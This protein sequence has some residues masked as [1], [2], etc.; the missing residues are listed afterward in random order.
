[1]MLRN[2]SRAAVGSSLRMI[3][4]PID[5][6]LAV[7][8]GDRA[9]VT[10]MKLTLDRADART[11]ELA[12]L[13]LGDPGLREDAELRRKAADKRERA[14]NLRAEAEL[15][16]ERADQLVDEG[17]Q[18]AARRRK[19]AASTA[20]RKRR[21]AQERRRSTKATAT[22]RADQRRDAAKSSAAQ[23]AKVI[24]ERNKHSRLEQLD[25]KQGAVQKKEVALTAADEARRLRRA[26]GDA[27]GERKSDD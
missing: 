1:M 20:K 21:Q 6:L 25:S 14:L 24:E 2:L 18:T 19:Q 12:G 9:P 17:K 4:W 13:V 23:A 16:S 26:A 5:G 11:R 15:R 3:R 10:A 27:K 7:V 8:G 22:R